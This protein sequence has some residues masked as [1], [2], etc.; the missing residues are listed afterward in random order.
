MTAKSNRGR[1]TNSRQAYFRLDHRGLF[2]EFG[3]ARGVI[4]LEMMDN[5]TCW[6]KVGNQHCTINLRTGKAS[7]F[8]VYS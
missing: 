7:P 8:E 6:V 3:L 5:A 4:Q 1:R 2:D